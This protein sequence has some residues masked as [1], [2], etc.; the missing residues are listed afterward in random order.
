MTAA[1]YVYLFQVRADATEK[2]HITKTPMTM[3]EARSQYEAGN[4]RVLLSTKQVRK[5]ADKDESRIAPSDSP[6]GHAPHRTLLD[7]CVENA[8]P[9]APTENSTAA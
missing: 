7:A 8:V 9:S 3:D 6:T 1:E 5:P 4:F 2:F